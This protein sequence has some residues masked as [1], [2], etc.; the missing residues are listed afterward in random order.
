LLRGI[1]ANDVHV[2]VAHRAPELRDA[3][4][5]KRLASV[6]V[7]HCRLVAVERD[8]LAEPLQL[9]ARRLEVLK[10]RLDLAEVH[11]HEPARGIVDVDEQNAAWRPLLEPI[12]V[13]AVDLNQLAKA[14]S[15]TTRLDETLAE[16]TQGP[17]SIGVLHPIL[18]RRTAIEQ[19]V[20]DAAKVKL[21]K[22]GIDLLDVH[23]KRI[24]YEPERGRK[25]L[26]TDDFGASANRV[27][28]SFRR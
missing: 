14:V 6:D 20:R 22:L 17:G 25:D 3:I 21:G 2:E 28:L 10:R 9:A 7:E 15:A 18:K 5:G 26:R 27:A 24:N 16:D 19:E 8:R 13:A 11:L 4:A 23:F 12:V 1:G